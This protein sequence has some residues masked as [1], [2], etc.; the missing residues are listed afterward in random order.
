MLLGGHGVVSVSSNVAPKAMRQ[1]CDAALRGVRPGQ[2]ARL[3]FQLLDLHKQS[4]L[5]TQPGA[6]QMGAQAPGAH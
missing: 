2:A 1:L 3:Q 4:V 6:H 5:R